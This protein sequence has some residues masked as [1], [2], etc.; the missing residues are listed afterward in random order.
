MMIQQRC[1]I[2]C[3][4]TATKLIIICWKMVAETMSLVFKKSYND[5][6]YIIL[7][8]YLEKEIKI[9]TQ[10]IKSSI[11]SIIILKYTLHINNINNKIFS[12]LK[13]L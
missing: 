9:L 6:D 11:I 12:Y 13:N 1:N 8:K 4:D 7:R 5:D 10:V 2:R 3:I